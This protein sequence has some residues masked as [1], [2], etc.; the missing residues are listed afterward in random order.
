MSMDEP[1]AEDPMELVGVALPAPDAA[2]QLAMFDCFLEEFVL[3]GYSTEQVLELC[4]DPFYTGL[5]QAFLALG[6][7]AVRERLQEWA[8][9]M[10]AV[11]TSFPV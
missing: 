11:E 9:L 10:R 1:D 5:N 8:P 3:L 7:T 2:A 4:R 6:E